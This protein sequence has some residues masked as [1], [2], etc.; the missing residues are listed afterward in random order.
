[1]SY[2][3]DPEGQAILIRK[4]QSAGGDFHFRR[5]RFVIS[6]LRSVTEDGCEWYIVRNGGL[7]E[8]MFLN[9]HCRPGF[10]KLVPGDK[11]I[12]TENLNASSSFTADGIPK[13][14]VAE[15]R[16]LQGNVLYRSPG[17]LNE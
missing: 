1:M 7:C 11:I 6:D 14:P 8:Y 5:Y 17:Y 2:S 9:V 4:S 13:Q 12:V 15:A 3:Y 10:E 16:D